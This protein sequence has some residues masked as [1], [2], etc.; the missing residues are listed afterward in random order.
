MARRKAKRR[1]PR[2]STA[3]NIKQ[4]IMAFATLQIVSTNVTGLGFWNFLTAGTRL[5]TAG[6][7]Q[8]GTPA[9]VGGH[10]QIITLKELIDGAQFTTSAANSP[11]MQIGENLRSNLLPMIF[12]LASLKV[13]DKVLTKLGV[14]R[15]FNKLSRSIGMGSVVR[16]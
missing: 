2:R 7:T 12:S 13:A 5:N 1:A 3:F 9:G 14:S 4:A 15:S 6:V 10:K 8:S 11:I 16:A